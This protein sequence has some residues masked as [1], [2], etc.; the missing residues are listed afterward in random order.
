M[1]LVGLQGLLLAVTGLAFMV[2]GVVSK[3]ADTLD[4][5]L[6]GGITLI[7]GVALIAVAKGLADARRWARAPALTWQLILILIGLNQLLAEPALAGTSLV[8]GL[9]TVV[10]MFH[11]ATNAVLED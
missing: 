9:L 8:V 1:L 2:A 6:I 11:P 4:A 10:A 3:S 5:E 7:G